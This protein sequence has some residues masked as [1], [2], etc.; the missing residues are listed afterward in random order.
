MSRLLINPYDD[1]AC[2]KLTPFPGIMT[3]TVIDSNQKSYKSPV[4]L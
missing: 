2:G 4:R 1:K 3:I